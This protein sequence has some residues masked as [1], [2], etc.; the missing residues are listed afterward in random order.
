MA[1]TVTITTSRT[2]RNTTESESGKE[3]TAYAAPGK[4][5]CFDAEGGGEPGG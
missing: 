4:A 1:I 5:E 3:K 2:T